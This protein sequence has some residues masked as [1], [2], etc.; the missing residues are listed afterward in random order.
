MSQKKGLRTTLD[1]TP[2]YLMF[3]WGYWESEKL[4]RKYQNFSEFHLKPVKKC[5]EKVRNSDILMRISHFLMVK[6]AANWSKLVGTPYYGVYEYLFWI[7]DLLLNHKTLKSISSLIRKFR[8][9][10]VP[11][12]SFFFRRGFFY[13]VFSNLV[14]R[15]Y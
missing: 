8:Q 12:F 1:G 13:F 11:T 5:H 2:A 15:S 3:S 7:S 4:S 10:L 9:I 14:Q 6:K